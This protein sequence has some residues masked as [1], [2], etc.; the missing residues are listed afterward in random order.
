MLIAVINGNLKTKFTDKCMHRVCS[1]MRYNR[2]RVATATADNLTKEKE[3]H[4]LCDGDCT[5]NTRHG[6][7]KIRW[8]GR[9]L[10]ASNTSCVCSVV[11]FVWRTFDKINVYNQHKCQRKILTT[12][13]KIICRLTEWGLFRWMQAEERMREKHLNKY[14]IL[15]L[16]AVRMSHGGLISIKSFFSCASCFVC[17][18][19]VF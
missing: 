7:S 9:H 12:T 14:G 3:A 13:T 4:K 16:I 10:F 11:R 19:E 5:A 18:H 15:S 1:V 17:A 2:K 6:N 8:V